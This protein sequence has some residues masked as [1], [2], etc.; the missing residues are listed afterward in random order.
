M[1]LDEKIIEALKSGYVCDNCTGR[2]VGNLLSGLSNEERGKILKNYLAFLIDSGEKINVDSSNFHGI[3]FRNVK[4]D[5]KK[6][7]KC[8]ICKNFFSE[9]IDEIAKRIVKKLEG[10]E[11]KTFQIGSIPSDDILKSEENLFEAIGTDF[12]ESIKSEI[13]RELGKR[14]EKLTDKKFDLKNPD[15]TIIVDLKTNTIKTQIRSLY[16]FGRYQKLFRGIPQSK[17]VCRKC[18]GKGC[19]YCKGEGK[20]YKTSIQE[21][22]EKPLLKAAK[23][24]KSSF[25]GAGREDID[26]I[27]IGYRPFVIELIKPEKRKIDIKKLGIEINKSKKV[28]VRDLKIVDSGKDLIVRIKTDR[29]EKTYVAEVEFKKKIDRKKLKLLKQLVKEP[30]IQKTPLRVVH[31]RA[32]K[33]RKRWVKG[34][35]YK[36]KGDKL[37]LK[38]RTEAGLY[39]KELITGDDERTNPNVAKI[40][41][42]KVRKIKLD[43]V[44]IHS[45]NLKI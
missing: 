38:F 3:K 20:L 24:K 22:I 12:V 29:Y 34:I 9:K 19:T 21:I 33:F 25:S 36:M 32:D 2:I 23:S 27:C 43:V 6:P 37:I 30:I 31:R 1:K 39:I 26:A 35:S 18:N 28:K 16:V 15:V 45:K 44:N 5:I 4:L 11:Y 17:W 8:K 7:E 40:L 42:N 41:D 14:M 13:N 10:V